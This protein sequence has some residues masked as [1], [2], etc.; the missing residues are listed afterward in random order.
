MKELD[1][2]K[3]VLAIKLQKTE[4]SGTLTFN[5]LGSV[6]FLFLTEMTFTQQGC[7]KLIKNYYVSRFLFQINGPSLEMYI[8]QII[9]KKKQF[10]HFHQNFKS[11]F[12]RDD[13]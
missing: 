5:S 12:N 11:V 6:R 8:L 13:Y 3:H 7:T 2:K 10:H 1:S 4:P 9:L